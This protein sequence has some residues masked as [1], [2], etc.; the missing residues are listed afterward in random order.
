MTTTTH[1]P[2]NART[3]LDQAGP[4]ALL[5]IGARHY[6]DLGTGVQFTVGNGR[7]LTCRIRLNA[8]D[9]YDVKFV[10]VNVR[11]ATEKLLA[12]MVNVH[13]DQLAETLYRLADAALA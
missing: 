13:A 5:S 3:I 6:V 9:L 1:R 11:N 4:G 7:G 12:D 10:R 2:A 8:L